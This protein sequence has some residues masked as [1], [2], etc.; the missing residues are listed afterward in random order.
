MASKMAA[1]SF[2]FVLGLVVASLYREIV[3][4]VFYDK[5]VC[6]GWVVG[7]LGTESDLSV[8]GCCVLPV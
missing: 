3:S 1:A 4:P 6:E 8:G 5:S 7:V 2:L